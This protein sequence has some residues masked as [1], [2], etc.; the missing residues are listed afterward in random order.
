MVTIVPFNESISSSF[1][2]AVISFD[3]ASV[4]I[5]ASTRRCSQPQAL[6][7]CNADLPLARSN[8]RRRTFPPASAGAGCRLLQ[9]LEPVGKILP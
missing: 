9:H 8:E 4:A 1:G 5:C 3:F 7:M 2:M 6:T